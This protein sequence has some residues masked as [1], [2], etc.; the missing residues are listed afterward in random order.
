MTKIA[1]LDCTSGVSGDMLLGALIDCGV[2]LAEVQ[3][4]VESLGL[5]DCRLEVAETRRHGFRAAKLTVR[6]RPEHAHRHLSDIVQMIEGGQLDDRARRLAIEIFTRL[7]EAEAHVHGVPVEKVH[8]HEVGAVDSIADI[9]GCAIA[10][11][12]LGAERLVCSPVPTGGG[13][14]EIAHGRCGVPAPA[15]AELLKGAVLADSSV[16]A[17]LTTPTGA[18][19]LAVL[20]DEYGPPPA[21]RLAATGYGAGDRDL[22][23]Q[24]NILRLL[25]GEV[26]AGHDDLEHDTVV[27][28]ETNL[29]DAA[30][31]LIGY[32]RERLLE[33]GALDV[34][35]IPVQMKKGRPGVLLSV[36]CPPAD[37]QALEQL[38]LTE[39]GTLGVRR[40]TAARAKLPRTE[41]EVDT[42]FGPIAC[43]V[44]TLPGDE[45]LVSPEYEACAAAAR[46]TGAAL[47]QVF[48][49]A[50]K[51]WSE[52]RGNE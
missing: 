14:I 21:M 11:R 31:E 23:E 43:K 8:F 22:A 48:D 29:D 13:T 27:V 16:Q 25:V 44:A 26:A 20:V 46:M 49:A 35:T 32:C 51:A 38:L 18:A 9:V 28:L 3:R 40:R 15:T 42:P 39:T 6:H 33:A 36:L 12:L 19:L 52:R 10:W 45:Q 34:L 17:E 24:A 1:Y 50:R 47:R 4:G 2:E 5:P 37:A 30:G 7:G 41:V